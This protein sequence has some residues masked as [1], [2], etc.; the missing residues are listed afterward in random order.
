MTTDAQIEAAARSDAA[1]DGRGW[2]AMA[3]TDRDRYLARSRAA[4]E[5]AER[6]AWIPV[7]EAMSGGV[8]L[9]DLDGR[10]EA[11]YWHPAMKAFVPDGFDRRHPWVFL[12]PTNGVNGAESGQYGPKRARPLPAPPEEGMPA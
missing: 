4:L 8:F 2:E 12:D 5:A 7:T 11:A 3:R 6:A 9:V 1:F 10:S